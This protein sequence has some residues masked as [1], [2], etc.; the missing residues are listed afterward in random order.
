[1]KNKI[2]YLETVHEVSKY[3]ESSKH[4]GKTESIDRGRNNEDN[5]KS[6]EDYNQL[7]LKDQS[8]NLLPVEEKFRN[9]S[10]QLS[11]ESMRDN[12]IDELEILI[13]KCDENIKEL[14]CDKNKFTANQNLNESFIYDKNSYYMPSMNMNNFNLQNPS[15]FMNTFVT[16]KNYSIIYDEYS[17]SNNMSQSD[18]LSIIREKFIEYQRSLFTVRNNLIKEKELEIKK[19]A[20]EIKLKNIKQKISEQ[21]RE[22]DQLLNK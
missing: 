19:N 20:K 6:N 13:K 7:I 8:K 15:S 12:F 5:L 17:S 3:Y 21:R 14:E 10:I 4:C 16:N 11:Q 22:F 18:F 2:L 1:L 9:E